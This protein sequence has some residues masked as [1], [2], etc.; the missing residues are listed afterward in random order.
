MRAVALVDDDEVERLDGDASG[1]R[2][3]A[4]APWTSAVSVSNSE[5]FLVLL[6]EVL[7]ALEHRVEPLDR[8]DADLAGRGDACC[9]CRCWTVY[10]SV[11]L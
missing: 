3:P 11:N 6:R 8:R 9:G 2:R 5:L 1:C 7:L 10:S 4:A